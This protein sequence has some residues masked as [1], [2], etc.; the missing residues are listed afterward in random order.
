MNL[1]NVHADP[2]SLLY[3]REAPEY[4]PNFFWNKYKDKPEEL[5]AREKY[6]AKSAEY[7]LHMC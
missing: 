7:A 1:Y 2:Q 4:V 6:I 3:F 5:K